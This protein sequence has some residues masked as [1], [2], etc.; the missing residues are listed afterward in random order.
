M[1]VTAG[2]V[3]PCTRFLRPLASR[4]A[5]V[6]AFLF[7]GLVDLG[8]PEGI[9]FFVGLTPRAGVSHFGSG[10][11]GARAAVDF[12]LSFGFSFSFS[13]SYSLAFLGDDK[14]WYSLV[15]FRG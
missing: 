7:L 11:D 5:G 6:A 12:F 4:P 15:T 13:F 14:L 10:E 9:N 1:A 3:S 8:G 2:E